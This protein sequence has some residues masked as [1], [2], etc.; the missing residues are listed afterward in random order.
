MPVSAPIQVVI[1]AAGNSARLGQPKQLLRHDGMR[2]IDRAVALAYAAT[3]SKPIVVLGA[4][5]R[6]IQP[7]S[8][9][10]VVI[11]QRWADGLGGSIAAGVA[12]AQAAAAILILLVDQIGVEHADLQ[13]FIDCWRR[14]PDQPLVARFGDEV[15][16]PVIFPPTLR[17]ALSQLHGQRGAKAVLAGTDYQEF[18]MESAAVDVDV[19]ADLEKLQ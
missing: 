18:S 9:A 12:Q 19:P 8:Q 13:A 16:P 1:P 6:Q 2:L 5:A 7:V 17:G 3:E 14:F 10:D 11:H 4:N 15:G